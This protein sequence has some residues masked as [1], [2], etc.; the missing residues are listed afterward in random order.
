MPTTLKDEAVIAGIG[1]TEFSKNS[2]RSELQLACEAVKAALDDC[3]LP[4]SKVDGLVTFSMDT[5]DE[6]EVAQERVFQVDAEVDVLH[7]AV[8]ENRRPARDLHGDRPG[9]LEAGL[10]EAGEDPLYI[11]RRMVRFASEDVGMADPNALVI[12]MAAQQAVHFVG[13]PEAN[14]ALAQAAVYLATAPKSNALYAGYSAVQE[15]IKRGPNDPVPL[16]LRNAVTGLMRDMEYGKGYKYAHDFE[17]HFAVQEHLPPALRE[18]RYYRP[19]D[20]GYEREVG[21]RLE[22]W[23]GRPHRD[24]TTEQGPDAR[25]R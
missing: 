18:R 13:L 16:H 3:G 7:P 11:A 24:H 5:N 6:V 10:V 8:P 14:L 20:Q 21:E 25:S 4:P 22:R 2:G 9:R 1:Q 15:D 17:G 23:W 19:S 12:A